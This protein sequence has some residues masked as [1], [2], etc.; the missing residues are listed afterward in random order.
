MSKQ[1]VWETE[2]EMIFSYYCYPDYE[3][4]F[5]VQWVKW[6]VAGLPPESS[7]LVPGDL[8]YNLW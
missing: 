3:I 2:K 4:V 7:R 6:V 1:Y 5:A 8:V